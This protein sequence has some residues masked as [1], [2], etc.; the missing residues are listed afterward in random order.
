MREI[1]NEVGVRPG[2]LYNHFSTKQDLL[3]HLMLSHMAALMEAWHHQLGNPSASDPL[4]TFVR[5]HIRYHLDRADEVFISYMELRNLEPQNFKQVE[6]ERRKYEAILT[7][8]LEA[9]SKA[10]VYAVEDAKVTTRAI[11]A[12]LTAIPSWYRDNGA[13]SRQQIEDLYSTM[14][15]KSVAPGLPYEPRENG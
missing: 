1:A 12:M 14:V 2:A 3:K 5:F 10:G 15:R 8:I 4:D 11:I 7:G 9:G 6:T 13:L